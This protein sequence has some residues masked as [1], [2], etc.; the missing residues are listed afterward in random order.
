MDLIE[1]AGL[2]VA[3]LGLGLTLAVVIR[4]RQLVRPVLRFEFGLMSDP[5]SVPKSLR[6]ASARTIFVGTDTTSRKQTIVCCPFRLENP[7]LLPVTDVVL[8]L[9]YP[10]KYVLDDAVFVNE[11]YA[12]RWLPGSREGWRRELVR[13]PSLTQVSYEL[14][15]IR[16]QEAI[17]VPEFVSL[18]P[19][20]PK[21]FRDDERL[22]AATSTTARRFG[23][24]AGFLNAVS[25]QASVWSSSC[26]PIAMEVNLVWLHATSMDQLSQVFRECGTAI[27]DG[28][29]PAPGRYWT[30]WPRRKWNQVVRMELAELH[31]QGLPVSR[32]LVGESMLEQHLPTV[33]ALARFELPPWGFY[34][35]SYDLKAL[36]MRVVPRDDLVN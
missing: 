6:S 36:G 29:R 25:I 11:H 27:W 31:L 7:T 15:V 16:A 19:L 14:P 10:S 8:R 13:L 26:A 17:V 22:Y 21:D 33:G 28:Q 35:Q 32:P 23:T 1:L 4:N 18:R 9:T 3:I 5:E 2:A 20:D 34:G 30:P 24:V 12:W